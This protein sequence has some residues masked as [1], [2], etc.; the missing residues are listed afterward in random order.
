MAQSAQAKEV[1][2][3]I[4]EEL[5]LQE[6]QVQ[7]QTGTIEKDV[8]DSC[9]IS[10]LCNDG[11][12][13][14]FLNANTGL[15]QDWGGWSRMN[16]VGIEQGGNA[17][18]IYPPGSNLVP[19][20]QVGSINYA[21]DQ[22]YS[23]A[24]NE[25]IIIV[26]D[27]ETLNG[28]D[29]QFNGIM[30]SVNQTNITN[31]ENR[32]TEG[33]EFTEQGRM[34]YLK[35][36]TGSGLTT[37]FSFEV[38]E[39]QGG[40]LAVRGPGKRTIGDFLTDMA[41]DVDEAGY[42]MQEINDN[43]TN[44]WD[45]YEFTVSPYVHSAQW[46][47]GA[48]IY[49]DSSIEH[50]HASFLRV[51]NTDNYA[52]MVQEDNVFGLRST[53][54]IFDCF[55]GETEGYHLQIVVSNLNNCV[56]EVLT[57]HNT[58]QNNNFNF[59]LQ[60][61]GI[62]QSGTDWTWETIDS[63]GLHFVCVPF[64]YNTIETEEQYN[65]F[66]AGWPGGWSTSCQVQTGGG[67]FLSGNIG[68]KRF[69][70]A[71]YKFLR[72]KK[73][74]E[75]QPC[76]FRINQ[77]GIKNA[78]HSLRPIQVPTY[79]YRKVAVPQYKYHVLDIYD[80]DKVPLALNFNSGDLR[81][82]SKRSAGYSKTFE[83]P[84]SNRNN[85]FLKTMTADGSERQQEDISWRKARIS[86][87]GIVVF[88]GYA[89]IEQSHTGQGGRYSCHIL[90]DPT[91]WPELIGEKNLC[92]LTFPFHEKSFATIQD[93]WTKTV[94]DIPY[95]YPVIN[96]G[97]WTKDVNAN[98]NA[99]S[100]ADFHPATYVKAIVD[101][102]F[103]D[104]GYS[105][106]S[107]F[108]NTSMFKKLIIPYTS[109][110]EYD[111][112]GQQELGEDGDFSATAAL[113]AT[114]YLPY[115]DP[116]G[117]HS[118]T[119]RSWFPN[120]PCATG[121]N[122]YSPGGGNSVQ[123]GYVVPFTGRYSI[124]Y[125]ARVRI[126]HPSFACSNGGGNQGRWA[127]WLHV[128]GL[129]PMPGSCAG[130]GVPGYYNINGSCGYVFM[131]NNVGPGNL[132]GA[133]CFAIFT[134]ESAGDWTTK[135]FTTEID[136]QQGDV[137]QIGWY[138]KNYRTACGVDCDVKNQELH[139]Y[140]IPEQGFVPAYDV[141]LSH[142]L[143]CGTKQID[144]LKG[145]TEMF[146]LY[147]TA[148]ND[149]RIVT[150]EPY[151]DFYGG[152]KVIDWSHKIDRTN[153]TDKFLIDELAKTI[154][155]KYKEDTGDDIVEIYNRDMGTELWSTE[156]THDELYRKQDSEIGTTVFSPTFRIKT[157]NGGDATFVNSGQ[158]P[159]M[160]CMWSGDPVNWGWFNNTS[161]PDYS[162][163]FKMRILN[164]YGLSD[165]T[166]P[167]SINDDNGNE[168]VLNHYPYA[169]TYNYNHASDPGAIENNL[170][171]YDIGSGPAFQRGLF[172]M[173]YG[174]WYEKVSGGA[175]LRTC[176]MDLDANDISQFDFRDC[177]KL[178]MDGGVPTYWTVN[179]IID[180][181]PGKNVLT[182]VE[183]VEFKYGFDRSGKP[184]KGDAV[185]YATVD[186]G[187]KPPGGH[188]VVS[189]PNGELFVEPNGNAYYND[190]LDVSIKVPTSTNLTP[191][192]LIS[193][194]STPHGMLS[195]SNKVIETNHHNGITNNHAEVSSLYANTIDK[196][197]IAF[198]TG[199][200]ATPDQ[201]VLG[202]YNK[203]NSNHSF[204]VGAGYR[205]KETGVYERINAISI[206]KNG[207]FSV[208]GGE[209]VAEFK[210]TKDMSITGDVYYTDEDGRKK[211]VY[212]KERIDNI[213]VKR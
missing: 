132:D 71:Q 137:L 1:I 86:A 13:N 170:S 64:Y 202:N 164:Y 158:W 83:L 165:E 210:P 101:K 88:N 159:I 157:A 197:G 168:V 102:I 44:F 93:S 33:R 35:P 78:S 22:T 65:P 172:D 119:I 194:P 57:W 160:P 70:D 169:Y 110:E 146:N 87:N 82:P 61:A 118:Q 97:K 55:E 89:R 127:A 163:N 139:I 196:N 3:E 182:K 187:G 49:Y 76:S 23:Q 195:N 176:M 77:F 190:K 6:F 117:V 149:A 198:G 175:A 19:Y 20:F 131:Q 56:L 21:F 24:V 126:E 178:E 177:I 91:Y 8:F 42:T 18:Q 150:V 113:A 152:G 31:V 122:L 136:C 108:M 142:S 46:D 99:H 75:S 181:S 45:N 15:V 204:Q 123:N 128:N 125:R 174:R 154:V 14:V 185:I 115:I 11:N 209:V 36:K 52:S 143:G 39:G 69:Y 120:I 80:R 212:L 135:S 38:L 188:G 179:K 105:V 171:W 203:K 4:G 112:N 124:Y 201:V 96:Y 213:E 30:Y 67:G 34:L 92:E 68:Q 66:T 180:Y 138:G 84:A 148:D 103:D 129:A 167:W 98:Q 74:D 50:L 116:T 37:R 173:Y 90:Q 16:C 48:G 114:Q 140:P 100:T 43:S 134:G 161:R 155:C 144:F 111:V 166:G 47:Y 26:F 147:W 10:N 130:N 145:I 41:Q 205:N 208:Y 62:N 199:L 107:N 141:D 72:I 184:N 211:K 5:G 60:Y 32:V 191:E 29:P 73:I 58:S 151:D 162:T 27:L 206:D 7:V 200:H 28:G 2:L 104:I 81:D 95:V 85:R 40:K 207:Q 17:P 12:G 59:A 53:H 106:D 79:N 133:P 183:L 9:N 25:G 192:I 51:G 54:P 186:N 121:C 94:D 63:N 153:W 193:H 109:D 156:I 189:T